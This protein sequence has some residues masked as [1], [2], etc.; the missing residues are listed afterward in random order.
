MSAL[1]LRRTA[2]VLGWSARGCFRRDITMSRLRQIRGG[3]SRTGLCDQ[4]HSMGAT[5][6]D[7][8]R[9][10]RISMNATLNPPSAETIQL[11]SSARRQEKRIQ[12]LIEQIDSFGDARARELLQECL[13]SVLALYGDGLARILQLIQNS[14]TDSDKIREALLNDK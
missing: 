5:G 4:N 1:F 6:F 12:E 13:Q 3:H 14:G 10:R 9:C 7:G 8:S 11:P 2:K